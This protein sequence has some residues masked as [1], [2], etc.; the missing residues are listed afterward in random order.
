MKYAQVPKYQNTYRLESFNPFNIEVVDNMVR[1][2]ME[3]KLSTVTSYHP[4]TMAKLC[5]EIDNEL[6]NALLKKDYDR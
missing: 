3:S 4:N 2:T 5:C 1:D 6:Q